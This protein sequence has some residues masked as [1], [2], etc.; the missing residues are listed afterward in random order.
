M[1]SS[2]FITR[3]V[4][5]TVL[6]LVVTLAG[7]V[8]LV[9]LPMTQYPP[10]SPPNVSIEANYPGASARVVADSVAAPIEQE[11]NGVENMLY[12]SSNSSNSGSYSLTVTFKPGTNLAF[13][14]V[15][16]Q[17]RVNLAMPLLP[18]V[19]RQAGVTT[20]KRNPDMLM[21]I[22]LFSPTREY[23]QLY[24]SNYSAINI[25]EEIA[26][27]K[28]VGD[29]GL[30]GNLDYSMRIWIDPDRLTSMG[31]TAGDV[32]SAIREQNLQFAAGQVGRSPVPDGQVFE[33]PLHIRGRL[34]LPEEFAQIVIR[35]TEDGRQVRIRDVGRV[36]LGA[37]NVDTSDKF[38]GQ[39]TAN[40]GVFQLS[41]ANALEVGDRVRAKMAELKEAFPP[42]LDYTIA[43]DSTRFIRDSVHGVVR[44]LVEAVILVAVVVLLFLQS[45][46]AAIIPL[47][48]V[49]VAIVGTFAAMFAL[50]FTLNTLTLFGLV[51]AIGIVVDDAIVVVEA[52][53]QKI[54]HGM[55]PLEATRLAM[56][57]VSG[58]VIAT[59]LVL[60]AVFVPCAFLGGITGL[61]FRQFAVT[62]AVST[63]L[64][65][66]NSLTLSP[67]LCAI[68]LKPRGARQDLPGRVINL[69][70]GWLFR[71]FNAGVNRSTSVYARLVGWSVRVVP[72]VLM[73]YA[74]LVVLTG[75]GLGQLPT[76]YIPSQDQGRLMCAVQLP[77]ASSLERTQKVLDDVSS[78]VREMPGVAHTIAVAGR[79][80]PLG[81]NGAN[82]GTMLITLD[83]I[84]KRSLHPSRSAE[85]IANNLRK[86]FATRVPD[87]QVMV[88]APPAVPGLGAA[89]G[90]KVIIE[91]ISGE[92][93]VLKLQE[94]VGRVIGEGRK[95][96]NLGGLF[97]SF[98]ADAP[99]LFVDVD[100]KQCQTMGVP[101]GDVFEAQQVFL[102]SRYVNDF[103]RFGRTWQVN[104]QAEGP[105]RNSVEDAKRI[106][107]RNDKG[108]MV[109]LG[110]VLDIREVAGPLVVTR[111]N[112]HLAASVMGSTAPGVSSG[113]AITAIDQLSKRVL[114][115]GTAHE[116][117]EINY[118][119]IDA[120]K[121]I[122]NQ[123]IFPLSVLF[124]FLVLAA[125]YESWALPMAVIPI[126]PLCVLSSMAGVWATS[127]DINVFTQIGFVV[128]IGLACKNAVLIVE[129]ARALRRT[130]ESRGDAVV[131]ASRLRLRPIVMTSIAFIL[132][133]VPLVFAT[134][135]GAEMRRALG[136]AV[137]SGMIGVT[138]FGLFFTPVCFIVV[139]RLAEGRLLRATW[140]RRLGRSL[141]D[142]IRLRPLWS[143]AS[144]VTGVRRKH[145]P[146]HLVFPK[147]R[148]ITTAGRPDSFEGRLSVPADHSEVAS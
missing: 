25:R 46:R 95:D 39:P 148:E 99:Q 9:N 88:M 91:D 100:R 55:A 40:I 136:T 3:P 118:I 115:E 57:E 114:P 121:N 119:Q 94:N 108:G 83:P 24:M 52:V 125:Q 129:F 4:F 105:Y 89:G 111:Y 34:V 126:V 141:L 131:E 49:P 87:A 84:D 97:T 137:F 45:W 11:V 21:V 15:L 56:D 31:L 145:R 54:E 112:M 72:L 73:I 44:T 76:G 134:G 132:G 13:A 140:M 35:R 62:I 139:D 82:Y 75:W 74:G 7:G 65:A 67:A 37:K 116:W 50:G 117:T 79:S 29:V 22:N 78:M 2:F 38:D 81:A 124:V 113:Y 68:L 120:G 86:T 66:L 144:M 143:L 6:S 28:G 80:L 90:F 47:A 5:A 104:V 58:P 18:D 96:P 8:A 101:V 33:F 41:D 128:L 63:V 102:G 20:R 64:S 59:G 106:R 61:F 42:G 32:I 23:D 69:L 36:E 147:E 1:L 146:D 109:P 107:V 53:Q 127:S 17:N 60:V 92:N 14:Q 27:V 48:A 135:S 16:V 71:L 12:M 138:V 10:I 85:A 19:V 43:N 110:A 123:L 51:L 77:D 122:W 30:F 103:N 133:V 142:L 70:F 98:R 93:D 130:G 26:R